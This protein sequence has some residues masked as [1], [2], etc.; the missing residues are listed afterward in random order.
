MP[1]LTR[2]DQGSDLPIVLDATTAEIKQLTSFLDGSIQVPEI[3]RHLW[4][5]W[6]LCPRHSWMAA[7]VECELRWRPFGTSILYQDLTSRAGELLGNHLRSRAGR[8]RHLKAR[9]AC[10]TC[11][12]VAICG[13]LTDPRAEA[14]RARA[15]RRERFNAAALQSRSE[16]L[17]RSCPACLGGRGPTCRLHLL[18][19]H[20][21]DPAPVAAALGEL[22][23][24]I[25]IYSR[26]LTWKGP[27]AS[28]ADES[29]WIEALGW[30]S[31][32]AFLAA[33]TGTTAAEPPAG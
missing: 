22:A 31:G 8:V 6:G 23:A 4:R 30:F 19:D 18:G 7:V 15:N 14:Q 33:A 24:R 10:Y 3:R 2:Q 17:P 1:V 11:D 26:S 29:S 12:Y 27:I 16:W 5:S 32:W 28:P 25:E 20:E 21:S 13:G 9:A